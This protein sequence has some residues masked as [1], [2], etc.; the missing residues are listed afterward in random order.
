MKILLDTNV[1]LSALFWKGE[2]NKLL[3]NFISKKIK[4][5]ISEDILKEFVEILN[6]EEKFQVGNEEQENLIRGILAIAEMIDVKT[7][8]NIIKEH[9]KDNLVLE[10][11]L[12]GKVD[13]IISYDNHILNMLEFRKIKILSPTEFSK[14]I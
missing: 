1:W 7:K 5:L 13:Y 12:D 9:P 3:N 8:L 4:I 14:L 11:A 2:A 6:R 10:A